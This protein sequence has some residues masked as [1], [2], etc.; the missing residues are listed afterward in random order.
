MILDN[1]RLKSFDID[2][3]AILVEPENVGQEIF[4][5]SSVLKKAFITRAWLDRTLVDCSVGK[6]RLGAEVEQS[7]RRLNATKVWL[8]LEK[9]TPNE[10][11]SQF[12]N[13][14]LELSKPKK[15]SNAFKDIVSSEKEKRKLSRRF[16]K[17]EDS[18]P[19]LCNFQ[20]DNDFLDKLAARHLFNAKA[21]SP[22]GLV[23]AELT[24]DWRFVTGMG[25]A[26]V[27]ET[28]IMLH[29]VYGVPYIP[30]SS[31]KGVLRHY[32][33]EF[34]EGK[35]YIEMI[36]GKGDGD[37]STNKPVKGQCT[38]F[39]AFP[40]KAPRIELDVMTPHYP[41]YYSEG[42]PPADWQS[43]TP[44]HFL[45]VGKGTHFRFM[46]GL[47]N[48]ANV[49]ILKTNLTTW[50]GE[51]LQFRGIGAKTAVGYGYMQKQ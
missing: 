30:A 37:S 17:T 43:P 7:G 9:S 51:A 12:K 40:L 39:D 50:L 29:H 15:G 26:S 42:L 4:V 22:G 33:D 35:N 13:F 16:L 23:E 38:F 48:V 21:L 19:D 46:I 10:S 31:I 5:A 20:F 41:K 27:Y 47:P 11:K 28:N 44:I 1:L 2:R 49:E 8:S 18:K 3:N 24:P 36:F 45:T 34:T 14:G 6:C 32:L 25:E